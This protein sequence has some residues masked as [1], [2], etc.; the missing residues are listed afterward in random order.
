MVDLTHQFAVVAGVLKTAFDP[1][2]TRKE[3]DDAS[4]RRA[5]I[6]IETCDP[7]GHIPLSRAQC[8]RQ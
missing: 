3:P 7:T 6:T 8:T 1:A 2:D 4:A 5:S